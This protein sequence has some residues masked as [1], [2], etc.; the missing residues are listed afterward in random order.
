LAAKGREKEKK[1]EQV[2][3]VGWLGPGSKVPAEVVWVLRVPAR[4]S[5]S[6]SNDDG[7][8]T[9]TSDPAR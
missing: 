5:S 3:E 4:V 1:E 2:L 7:G 8:F 6:L 9:K